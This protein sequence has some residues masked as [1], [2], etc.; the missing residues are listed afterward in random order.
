VGVPRARSLDSFACAVRVPFSR[1]E[2]LFFRAAQAGQVSE[3][4][5]DHVRQAQGSTGSV[6]TH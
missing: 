6:R 5:S 2:K 4:A 3:G 1:K